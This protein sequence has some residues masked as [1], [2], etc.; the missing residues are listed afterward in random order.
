MYISNR[1]ICIFIYIYRYIPLL[2]SFFSNIHGFLKQKG[3]RSPQNLSGPA[4]PRPPEEEPKSQHFARNLDFDEWQ[5][6]FSV[7]I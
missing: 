4:G 6:G 7:Q 2:H 3:L 5:E 1:H